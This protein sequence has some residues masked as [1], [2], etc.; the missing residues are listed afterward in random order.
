M[1]PKLQYVT[2][3][4]GDN[5]SAGPTQALFEEC[6][7]PGREA[8]ALPGRDPETGEWRCYDVLTRGPCKSGAELA[9]Q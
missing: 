9:E 7:D 3:Q 5:N 8:M 4:E 1:K 2:F 6:T